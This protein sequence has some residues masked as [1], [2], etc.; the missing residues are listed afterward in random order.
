MANVR[1][2]TVTDLERISAADDVTSVGLALDE[3]AFRAFYDRTA[4]QLWAYLSKLTG[5][6]DA[7]DDLLQEAY[8]RFLR[9]GVAL[10]DE[11]HR[12]NYLFRIA[13]N[14][15]RDGARSRACRPVIAVVD[16][17]D[18]PDGVDSVRRAER[19]GDVGRV[20]ARLKPRDRALLWLAYAH[21]ASHQEIAGTLGLRTGSVKPLLFRARRR[22]AALLRAA[23][24][25]GGRRGPA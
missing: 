4:R 8:F 15:V 21:G 1:N 12:R 11:A 19:S 24:Y 25:E 14:L 22:L 7:A 6:A 3:E 5:D 16:D 13:T 17:G 2:M 10:E 18:V 9:A 20:L 23:G